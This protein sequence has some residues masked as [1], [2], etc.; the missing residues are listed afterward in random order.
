LEYILAVDIG[1]GSCR[2]A[3]YSRDFERQGMAAVAYPSLYSQPDW[4]E[5]DPQAIYAAVLQAI[6]RTLSESGVHSKD[7]LAFTLDSALHTFIG[8]AGDGVPVTPILTWADSR[9]RHL[10]QRWKQEDVGADV[11]ER[12]GCPLHPMYTFAKLAWFRAHAPEIFRRIHTV[13]SVKSYILYRLTGMLLEDRATASGSGLLSVT[14][15]DWDDTALKLAG[16]S[17]AHL[18]TLVDPDFRINGILL[19]AARRTGL[20]QAVPVIVGS[21]D[22]AMS[23]LGSGTIGSDQMTVMI[24]TSGAVRRPVAT[25]TLDPQQR[26]FCYYAWEGVWLAGGALNNGGIVLRWFRDHF[27]D[28]AQKVAR[29]RGISSYSVLCDEADAIPAGADGLVFLP[30]LAGERSPYWN[31]NVRGTLLGLSLQHGQAHMI[32]ALMEGICYGIWSVAQPLEALI[33]TSREIRVSGGFTRS[34]IWMQILA[35]VMGRELVVSSEPEASVLGATVLAGRALGLI[36]SFQC[37]QDK[38]PVV[39]IIHPEQKL[40]EFYAEQF[41]RYLHLYWKLQDEF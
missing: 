20:P 13:V 38:N 12:T 10:V 28:R 37:L 36:D 19:D 17:R 8:L 34:M 15:P 11:Y 16:I 33:G 1:T 3:L 31:A 14:A 27:G 7:I 9:A 40:H 2:S 41:K 39:Q 21:S 25:P 26:T 5:Q 32:R 22:A 30:F 24:G 4:A 18:P 6:V 23:S 35:N 29:D